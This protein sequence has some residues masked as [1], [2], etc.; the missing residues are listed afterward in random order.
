MVQ[1]LCLTL[2][3]LLGFFQQAAYAQFDKTPWPKTQS[4]PSLTFTDV[5]HKKWSSHEL[6]GRVV[7]LNLW[8]TWCEPCKEELPSL[9]ALAELEGGEK[10]VVLGINVNEPASRAI[11]YLQTHGL[12]IRTVSDADSMW[13]RQF[14]VRVY[15]TTILM[16]TKTKAKWRVVGAVDWTS[17]MAREWIDGLNQERP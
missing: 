4:T 13:A 14:N 8:A 10:V 16:D 6:K 11:K 3:I 5:Q 7:I 9:D 1:G 17:S 2:I 15:P 12:K